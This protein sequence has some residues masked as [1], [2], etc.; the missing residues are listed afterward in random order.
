ME[1]LSITK[2]GERMVEDVWFGLHMAPEGCDFEYMSNVAKAT[3]RAG[4][5]IFMITDHFMNMVN[6]SGPGKHPLECWTTLA[7]LA[8]VTHRIKLGPL[9][10]CYAYREPTV[11]AKMAT[12]VDIIS[13]GRLIMGIGAGWHEAEFKGYIGRF[14]RR[15]RGLPV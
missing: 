13:K 9:V 5:D 6:P 4:F 15:V 11:L 1:D 7:R 8:S 2:A 10:T 14:P 3:E 12:T